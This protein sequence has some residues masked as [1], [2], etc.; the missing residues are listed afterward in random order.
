MFISKVLTFTIQTGIDSKSL[1]L[2]YTIII[3]QRTI[4]LNMLRRFFMLL[5]KKITQLHSY[6]PRATLF[7]CALLALSFIYSTRAAC[8]HDT[9]RGK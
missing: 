5:I 1:F 4:M 2:N 8:I 7:S 6:A 9:L 3:T